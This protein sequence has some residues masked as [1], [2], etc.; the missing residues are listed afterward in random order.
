MRSIVLTLFLLSLLHISSTAQHEGD[1]ENWCRGGGFTHS[2]EFKV[3]TITGKKGI[4]VHFYN[5]LQEDCPA[6]EKCRDKAYIVPGDKIVVSRT[7]GNFVCSWFSPAKGMPTVGWIKSADVTLADARSNVPLTEW[8]GEWSYAYNSIKFTH[9]K[10]AGYLN[11]TG[12][13]LWRGLGDNVHVGE[14]DDRVEPKGNRLTVGERETDEYSCKA[15]VRMIGSFLVVRDNMNCGG[16]NVT[17]SGVY[18]RKR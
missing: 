13:A 7:F 17:F 12:D 4:K 9:N 1:P 11:V 14:L 6:S 3:G 18:R 2:N 8:L 16:A 5:D 10:L 15:T